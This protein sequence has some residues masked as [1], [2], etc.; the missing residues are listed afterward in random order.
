[1]SFQLGMSSLHFSCMNG[2]A[3]TTELLARSG[4]SWQ[5]RTKADKTPL[6]YAAQNGFRDV[7]NILVNLGADINAVDMVCIVL[8]FENVG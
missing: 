8:F 5:S 6:H 7:V 4:V 3:G 2:H 1:M